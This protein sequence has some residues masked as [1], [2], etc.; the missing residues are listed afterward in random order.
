MSEIVCRPHAWLNF[1]TEPTFIERLFGFKKRPAA[2]ESKDRVDE[3][4]RQEP[5]EPCLP[6]HRGSAVQIDLFGRHVSQEGDLEK[7][8]SDVDVRNVHK[9]TD[10][11]PDQRHI[12]ERRQDSSHQPVIVIRNTSADD[13][14]NLTR[15]V[16][17]QVAALELYGIAL[18][19]G[20]L[21]LGIILF[22]GFVTYYPT[23]AL[24]KDG[25][26]V[27]DYA[28]PCTAGGTL[29]LVAG[30]IICAYVVESSTS[31]RTFRPA[32]GKA[33][34]VW[35][36]R[37]SNV[38]DQAFAIFPRRANDLV[39]ATRR[40]EKDE[41][42]WVK[43]LHE[44][45]C[46]MGALTS[47][48]GFLLQ[49]NGLRGMH[50]SA[51]IV[52]LGA[53]G[54]M[55]VLRLSV[56]RNL[57]EL[58]KTK[59]LATGH[60]LDWMAMTLG[61]HTKAPW[62]GP[63]QSEGYS[64][65]HKRPYEWKLNAIEDPSKCPALERANSVSAE[66]GGYSRP[67]KRLP[68]AH[69]VMM[70]RKDLGR[71]SDWP[72]V[73]SMEATIL[74]RAIE[75]TMNTLFTARTGTFEWCLRTCG[76][77]SI[78][79]S[80]DRGQAEDGNWKACSDEIE[81]AMSLW[82]YSLCDEKLLGKQRK[83]DKGQKIDGID[84][85][86]PEDENEPA[87]RG[88]RLLGSKTS[89]L[90]RDVHWWLP[91]GAVRVLEAQQV[92][93]EASSG[94]T[95]EVE[96]NRIFGLASN[97]SHCS[98][99]S[100]PTHR[101]AMKEFVAVFD[102]PA[103]GHHGSKNSETLF[104]VESYAPLKRLL[105]QHL[106]STFMVAAAK[107]MEDPICGGAEIRPSD[108]EGSSSTWTSFGL[109]NP[110]LSKLAQKVRD[111]GLGTLEDVY[112]CIVPALSA[113]D[114]LPRADAI[115]DWTRA[116]ATPHEQLC[117]WREASE[118]YIWLFEMA[119]T[120]PIEDAIY[121][122]GT[123][124]LMEFW[125]AVLTARGMREA[126]QFEKRRMQDLEKVQLALQKHVATADDRTLSSLAR[127]FATQKREWD[128]DLIKTPISLGDQDL[129]FPKNFRFTNLH[130][131]A[132]RR[133]WKEIGNVRHSHAD[134]NQKDILGWTPLHYATMMCSPGT[135]KWLTANRAD[136]NALDVRGW[137]P[138]HWACWHEN[139]SNVLELLRE[140]A[141]INIRSIEGMAPIHYAAFRGN[142]PVLR[143][144]IEAGADVNLIDGT[145]KTPL[146]WAAFMSHKRIVEE[147]WRISNCRLRDH[148][149]RTPL[150]L[151]AISAVSWK[152]DMRDVISTI[153]GLGAE[154]DAKD[155]LGRT[156]L[157]LA[158]R[159][160]FA[161]AVEMLLSLNDDKIT[162]DDKKTSH[163]SATTRDNKRKT[164]R[165]LALMRD[166]ERKV[167]RDLA[168]EQGH[169]TVAEQLSQVLQQQK[170]SIQASVEV[171]RTSAQV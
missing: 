11:N 27:S 48:G 16:A 41:K 52:Q 54:I 65:E 29:L 15:N 32:V 126:E 69:R 20:V 125:R 46:V 81:A 134:I 53:T 121:A 28:F 17:K 144:F 136:A 101:Y 22:G 152:P 72:G 156:P 123:A 83:K 79:F 157:H 6:F 61:D 43:K 103:L 129:L 91:D 167:P 55:T 4:K 95:I 47:I 131:Y 84:Y 151:A 36:Q 145:G 66:S 166:N 100:L 64:K 59:H 50:W 115:V 142:L 109:H 24:P 92:N 120:F 104:A 114:K 128:T 38:S 25:Q 170:K 108:A 147:L 94:R 33:R 40:A 26:P 12:S 162:S 19:G 42:E 96:A 155:R 168:L 169:T 45:L 1:E 116:H 14:P 18:C 7:A 149:G 75:E 23:L 137:T 88:L 56:R 44:N 117:H 133:G 51:S 63:D 113:A 102:D 31:K 90:Q 78:R 37:C 161:E 67:T 74:A 76:D 58:P 93:E 62:L 164:P 86:S 140:G 124:L 158:A 146:L 122:N 97:D 13:T 150:H 139:P 111:T 89:A 130:R 8:L 106:F 77:D 138:L 163:V 105:T 57:A 153:V 99:E 110:Q 160:G 21:Q 141:D 39:I 118:A 82:L 85:T 135:V 98:P 143:S 70:I 10:S 159:A 5:E 34:L 112:L 60:E 87:K 119:K 171:P 107:A 165:D 71:L 148:N 35:L 9:D 154:V 68:L 3:N 132:C 80:I 127:L 49:L 30:M 2:L 73:A